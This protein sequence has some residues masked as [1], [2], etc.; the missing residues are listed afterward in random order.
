MKKILFMTLLTAAAIGFTACSKDDDSNGTDTPSAENLVVNEL[1]VFQD[2]VIKVD[3]QGNLKGVN[4]GTAFDDEEPTVFSTQVSDINDARNKFME[5]VR[6]FKHV[7]ATGNDITVSLKDAE[8][9]EQGKILF[10][11]GSGD[12]VAAMTY[13]GFNLPG[14]TKLKYML[15]LPESNATSRWKLWEVMTVPRSEEANPRGVCIREYSPGTPGMIICPTSYVSGYQS[16]RANSSLETLRQMATQIQKLG[17][18][19]VSERL[20]KAGLYSDL[21]KFYWSNTT[22][23]YFIFD[24]GHWKVRLSDGADQ[25]VSSWEVALNKNEANNCYT[26]W[27]NEKG[28]CW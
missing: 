23:L 6:D 4:V 22:K 3:A 12:E 5:L 25:Y 10:R 19:K 18:S 8:G 26:Y 27:F 21:T 14:I 11:E 24:N 9:N 13:E 15:R 17:V 28:E 20:E 16:W 2:R 1:C 7:S